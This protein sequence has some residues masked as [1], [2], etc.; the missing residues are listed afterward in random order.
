MPKKRKPEERNIS[1]QRHFERLR[2]RPDPVESRRRFAFAW[3][4]SISSCVARAGLSEGK[5]SAEGVRDLPLHVPLAPQPLTE[6]DI[7]Q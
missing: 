4:R 1:H 7:L 5:A 2:R 6:Q 3:R